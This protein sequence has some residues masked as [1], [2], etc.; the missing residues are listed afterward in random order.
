MELMNEAFLLKQFWCILVNPNSLVSKCLKA[1]Y[2]SN[3]SIFEAPFRNNYSIVWKNIWRVGM[4]ARDVM[5]IN[6][7]NTVTWKAD[8]SGC[9]TVKSAY[10]YL[11]KKKDEHFLEKRGE[12]SD[13][14][15]TVLFWKCVW[16]SPVQEKVKNFTWR[17]YHNLLPV[18]SNLR[19]RGC[20]TNGNCWFCGFSNETASHLFISCW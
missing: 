8:Q 15:Q 11:K 20:E 16:R 13:N 6:S 3:T 2:F 14:S 19:M 5:V 10:G 17:L 7:D 4:A 12:V 9:F 18:T 1:R